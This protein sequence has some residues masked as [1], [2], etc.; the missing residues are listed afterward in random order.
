MAIYHA[1]KFV[2]RWI[3]IYIGIAQLANHASR[4]YHVCVQ[5]C[6]APMM[7]RWNGIMERFIVV[8]YNAYTR[9]YHTSTYR[10]ARCM[11]DHLPHANA[12]E[13][14]ILIATLSIPEYNKIGWDVFTNRNI[15]VAILW[16]GGSSPRLFFMACG[17]IRRR[18]GAYGARV[19]P[20]S[21]KIKERER[22]SGTRTGQP[23]LQAALL[24]LIQCCPAAACLR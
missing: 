5:Q 16:D 22:Q 20:D 15:L 18:C 1:I 2:C 4:T 14:N 24:R 10:R 13:A 17:R 23:W 7:E 6:L 9:I 11:I 19:L 21:R 8:A 12:R 3:H